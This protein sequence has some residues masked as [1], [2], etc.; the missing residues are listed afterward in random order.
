MDTEWG[1][2]VSWYSFQV[3]SFT[4]LV[5]TGALDKT[6]RYKWT[7]YLRGTSGNTGR[8]VFYTPVLHNMMLGPWRQQYQLKNSV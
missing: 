5:G 1:K 6:V 8:L 4:W 7:I 2:L 3:T